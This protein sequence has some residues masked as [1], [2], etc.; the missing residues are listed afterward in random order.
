MG[1]ID[2]LPH[3]VIFGHFWTFS[4]VFGPPWALRFLEHLHK[5]PYVY[6]VIFLDWHLLW[7][8]NSK[9]IVHRKKMKLVPEREFKTVIQVLHKRLKVVAFSLFAGCAFF[10]KIA[11]RVLDHLLWN[12]VLM[13]ITVFLANWWSPAHIGALKSWWKTRRNDEGV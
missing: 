7:G 6:S 10:V 2:F 1:F 4:A 5:E 8:H 12:H 13:S 9:S 3:V 11:H